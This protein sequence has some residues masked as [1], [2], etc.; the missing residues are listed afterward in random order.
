MTLLLILIAIGVQRFLQ[1]LSQPLRLAWSGSYY[2]WC[3]SKIEYVTK[4]HG[5][6]GFAI[7]VIPVLFVISII[8]SVVFHLMGTV[9]YSALS[10]LLLWY[11]IDARDL[12]KQ[13]YPRLG[14]VNTL[15]KVYRD[16]FAPLFWFAIL[17]PVILALYYLVN[18][19]NEYLNEHPGFESKELLNYSQKVLAVL[20]WIPM[21]LFALG[22]ALVG[23]FGLV[24]KI[25]VKS[26]PAGFD[27]QLSLISH[28]G[29]PIVKTTEDAVNL[30]NRVLIV[31]L[32]AI[33]LITIGLILG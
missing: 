26:L 23:N 15:S 18:H 8:Y 2:R 25:W 33:A 20:D 30:L 28:C 14:P 9:G 32:V 5:L 29:Q 13:P 16:L 3:E 7:L 31:W 12:V 4:G 19:F 11:C 6:L 10:L 21:R 1:F 24:F 22:F 17:G 27:P